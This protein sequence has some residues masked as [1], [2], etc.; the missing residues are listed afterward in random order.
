MCVY[1]GWRVLFAR[2]FVVSNLLDLIELCL[3]KGRLMI[4]GNPKTGNPKHIIG[5]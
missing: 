2:G 1:I 4:N 3:H 5:I